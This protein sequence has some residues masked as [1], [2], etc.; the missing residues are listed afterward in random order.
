MNCCGCSCRY[1]YCTESNNWLRNCSGQTLAAN[2]AAF[3][4]K[5][6][7][8]TAEFIY[9]QVGNISIV[10]FFFVLCYGI[11]YLRLW[12]DFCYR[13]KSRFIYKIKW[14]TMEKRKEVKEKEKR[15]RERERSK[16]IVEA[17]ELNS[18]MF[19]TLTKVTAAAKRPEAL[20]LPAPHHHRFPSRQ[21]G[22][23][24]HRFVL[25]STP[26]H[27]LT[28]THMHTQRQRHTSTHIHTQAQTHKDTDTQTHADT[29]G[30]AHTYTHVSSLLRVTTPAEL[31][32]LISN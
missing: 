20:A 32:V 8:T 2:D 14:S 1:K 30:H 23:H 6:Y 29:H 9:V 10:F 4:D 18:I 15:E 16:Q 11:M 5:T 22:Y 28:H 19:A 7:F 21:H 12:T 31:I 27:T 13:F 17:N 3:H 24:R 25:L 26:T